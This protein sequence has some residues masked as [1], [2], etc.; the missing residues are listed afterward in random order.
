M[1]TVNLQ[2]IPSPKDCFDRIRASMAPFI[3]Q[4]RPDTSVVIKPN[5][6]VPHH[7]PGVTTSPAVLEAVVAAVREHTSRIRVVESNGLRNAWTAELA[8]YE[9][10]IPNLTALYDVQPVNMSRCS[11][12]R[13]ATK[14]QGVDVEVSL[15]SFLQDDVDFLSLFQCLSIMLKHLLVWDLRTNGG[16]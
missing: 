16:A 12:T 6:C 3:S 8:F 7:Q 1:N 5:F 13:I 14:V 11:T 10:G 4:I 9:H 2:C 15:P